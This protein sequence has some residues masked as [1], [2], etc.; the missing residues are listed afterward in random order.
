LDGTLVDS[1]HQ[2][3]RAWGRILTTLGRTP[4]PQDAVEAMVG[5]GAEKLVERGLAATGGPPVTPSFGDIVDSYAKALA[6]E[7]ISEADLYPGVMATL[8][9]F[10]DT[11]LAMAVCTNKPIAAAE[12]ALRMTGILPF[13]DLVVGDGSAP[14]LKP[15]SAPV[16]TILDK[17][18]YRPDQ[19]IMI[20]DHENDVKAARGA[21]VQPI[22]VSYG[23][24]NRNAAELGVTMIDRFD[25]LPAALQRNA[26]ATMQ[27]L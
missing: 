4:L 26:Q 13:F 19:A 17:L 21:G 27:A 18:G 11:G 6:I 5:D 24:P 12:T 10:A 16:K 3:T 9:L 23:Y 25:A 1:G 20:G 8:R 14:S 22:L 2:I 7:P 15:D